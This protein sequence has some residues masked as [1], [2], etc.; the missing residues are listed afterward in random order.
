MISREELKKISDKMVERGY[1]EWS[2]TMKGDEVISIF[3]LPK[4]D[5]L[6][7]MLYRH[8]CVTVYPKEDGKHEFEI[9]C[10]VNPG[11][12][13]VRSGKMSPLFDD[14]F[15]EKNLNYVDNILWTLIKEGF[16]V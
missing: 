5:G 7:D 14:K 8:A 3:F 2:H 1:M 13:Q 10:A 12:I 15:F 6:E 9:H 16:N 11:C 4:L